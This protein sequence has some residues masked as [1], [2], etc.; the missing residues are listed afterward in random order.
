M[1]DEKKIEILENVHIQFK[2]SVDLCKNLKIF[3]RNLTIVNLKIFEILTLSKYS[4]ADLHLMNIV[5][6]S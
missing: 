3:L 5:N 2:E 6:I 1:N 4:A